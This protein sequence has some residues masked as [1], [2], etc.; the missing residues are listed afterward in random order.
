MT[1]TL[2]KK[3]AVQKD[4]SQLDKAVEE[5]VKVK[6]GISSQYFYRSLYVA[7]LVHCFK[8]LLNFLR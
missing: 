7:Q 8:V 6:S 2:K 3:Y 5:C 4:L 1:S